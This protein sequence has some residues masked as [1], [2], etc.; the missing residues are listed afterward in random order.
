MREPSRKNARAT[1]RE[2]ERN[3]CQWAMWRE[4][5]VHWVGLEGKRGC[6]EKN[7]GARR[8]KKPK[9]NP[10]GVKKV[11]VELQCVCP[12]LSRLRLLVLLL[13]FSVRAFVMPHNEC[14]SYFRA[15]RCG[16]CARVWL[17]HS[18]VDKINWGLPTLTQRSGFSLRAVAVVVV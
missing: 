13:C 16:K 5:P 18:N 17:C 7:R 9:T 6:E 3:A 11:V 4:F 2:R 8:K 12:L 10:V 15:L 14:I 1:E